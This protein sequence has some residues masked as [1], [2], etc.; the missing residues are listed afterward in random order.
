MFGWCQWCGGNGC[1]VCE[2]K[3]PESNLLLT[4]KEGDPIAMAV[5]IEAFHID[6]LKKHVTPDGL[7]M[8]A[9]EAQLSE[10][11]ARHGYQD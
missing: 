8:P 9:L 6:N 1:L 11:K 4:V 3:A 2:A 7:D 10:I 5:L